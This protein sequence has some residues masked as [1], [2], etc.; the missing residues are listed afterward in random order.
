MSRALA[1]DD[2]E[3]KLKEQEHP[4]SNAASCT[5]FVHQVEEGL[6]IYNENDLVSQEIIAKFMNNIHHG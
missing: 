4:S 2:C 6:V 3:V 5:R 1:N